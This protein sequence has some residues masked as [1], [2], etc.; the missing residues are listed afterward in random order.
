MLFFLS[1]IV[2]MFNLNFHQYH[3]TLIIPSYRYFIGTT[4][5]PSIYP[6]PSWNKHEETLSGQPRTNNTCE[7]FNSSWTKDVGPYPS[8]WRVLE[9][10]QK[11]E[12]LVNQAVVENLSKVCNVYCISSSV[13]SFIIQTLSI[14]FLIYINRQKINMC[15]F[16]SNYEKK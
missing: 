9:E 4:D 6:V 12:R 8:L 1:L 13:H 11:R 5:R 7:G 3:E 15:S 16:D 2:E 14:L 10:L